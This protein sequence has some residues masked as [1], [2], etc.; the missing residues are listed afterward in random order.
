MNKSELYYRYVE[1]GLHNVLLHISGAY[2]ISHQY[3]LSK[4]LEN[5]LPINLIFGYYDANKPICWRSPNTGKE[6]SE[7]FEPRNEE[8]RLKAIRKI[9]DLIQDWN[10]EVEKFELTAPINKADLIKYRKHSFHW[11]WGLNAAL[12]E[13]TISMQ[14]NDFKRIVNWDNKYLFNKALQI[15][16]Q[17]EY[18]PFLNKMIYDY[19]CLM[20][21]DKHR[22][23]HLLHRPILEFE[24]WFMMKGFSIEHTP[25]MLDM[26]DEK[27]QSNPL[28]QKLQ[29]VEIEKQNVTNEYSNLIKINRKQI[30]G[31]RKE[32]AKVGRMA[33]EE[34]FKEMAEKNELD[35]MIKEKGLIHKES[36]ATNWSGIAR[37]I[38]VRSGKT[39]KKY[40]E[41][42]APYLL[43]DDEM[44]YAE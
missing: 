30:K 32:L 41:R 28:A 1:I 24:N 7:S 12:S 3:P 35:K 2:D 25:N 27:V 29:E 26:S 37:E 20:A 36:G 33:P 31:L 13:P 14:N 23:E 17:E 39:A 44:G 4:K 9:N 6:H 42:Y 11:E 43:K 19:L 40:A 5:L 8:S 10:E 22:E 16:K 15:S 34:R 21:P 18:V 38:G